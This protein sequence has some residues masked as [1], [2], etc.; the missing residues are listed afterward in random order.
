M[1]DPLSQ[2]TIQVFLCTASLRRQL[3]HFRT[4][5]ALGWNWQSRGEMQ[6]GMVGGRVGFLVGR[7]WERGKGERRE[8][9]GGVRCIVESVFS[10]SYFF[11]SCRSMSLH[12]FAASVL[13]CLISGSMMSHHKHCARCLRISPG[14]SAIVWSLYCSTEW[15]SLPSCS[16]RHIERPSPNIPE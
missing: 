3:W 5:I 9:G 2:A 15:S 11:A 10:T 7:L 13:F 1:L 12:I 14:E 6:E 8:E 4:Q 16:E